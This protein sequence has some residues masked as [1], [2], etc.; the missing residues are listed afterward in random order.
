MTEEAR[1][2]SV[3]DEAEGDLSETFRDDKTVKQRLVENPQPGLRWT[4]VLLGLLALEIGRFADGLIRSF[5][6]LYRRG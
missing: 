5:V 1:P 6:T 4:V 2:D 3:I